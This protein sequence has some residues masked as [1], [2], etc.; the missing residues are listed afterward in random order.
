MFQLE[1]LIINISHSIKKGL[2]KVKK[3]A[4]TKIKKMA[5]WLKCLEI[6][7]IDLVFRQINFIS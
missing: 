3:N 2:N 1:L 6:S 5:L 4:Q 7:K